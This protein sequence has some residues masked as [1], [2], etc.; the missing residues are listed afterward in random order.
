MNQN[1]I[2]A[3]I[4]S[5]VMSPAQSRLTSKA[6]SISQMS[7]KYSHTQ[8]ASLRKVQTVA[9]DT[10]SKMHTQRST[11]RGANIR[12]FRIIKTDR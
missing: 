10:N 3:N 1:Q 7:G 2:P 9:R 11:S 5:G 4:H 6:Q 12:D 8:T